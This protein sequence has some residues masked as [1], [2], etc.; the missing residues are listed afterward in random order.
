MSEDYPLITVRIPAYNHEK[1]IL[2]SLESV[3][4]SSY[5]NK[6]IVIIDDGSKDQ[7]PF[8]IESWIIK[9]KDKIP[10]YYKKRENH[11]IAATLNELIKMSHGEFIASLASDDYLL[12][13]G[14]MKRYLYLKNHP[15]KKAV[16][17]DTIIV[18]EN[19]EIRSKSAWPGPYN[20]DPIQFSTDKGIRKTFISQ[21]A[22]PGP[23][24]MVKK[25]I[26]NII[27][28]Y[29]T[30]QVWE[31]VDIYLK[32]ASENLIG[33][34]NEQVSAYRIHS[35]NTCRKTS[36][37]DR[38]KHHIYLRN[39]I[40]NNLKRFNVFEQIIMLKE[41]LKQSLII[42]IYRVNLHHIAKKLK[43]MIL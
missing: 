23:A 10:V 6:E 41:I 20:I 28:T 3:L 40:I 33:Y 8:I 4:Q 9:N 15:N 35:S 39:S 22:I 14:L 29:N 27:G 18:N 17:G 38:I 25:E 42:Y 43:K 13:D 11:G 31:D 5:P 2:Q 34:I 1:F 16:F 30:G 12:P 19:N 7:T 26:F 21:F 24:L 32:M 36:K 37:E